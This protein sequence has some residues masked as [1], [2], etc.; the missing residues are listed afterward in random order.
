MPN[1]ASR[2]V[3]AGRRQIRSLVLGFAVTG[4]FFAALW[5]TRPERLVRLVWPL[6]VRT[7][8]DIR[9]GPY[10]QNRLDLMLPRWSFQRERPAV[11][12][13]HGG[14]WR[15]GD[16]Y[17]ARYNLCRRYLSQ[18]F[19]VANVDYRLG[20]IPLAA[21][22]AA[23]AWRWFSEVAQKYGADPRRIVITGVSAGAHLA[24]LTAFQSPVQPA[25][26]VNFYAPSNLQLLLS[27]HLIPDVLFGEN[28]AS[29]ARRLSPQTY[30]RPGLPPV[31][32]VHGT[33]DEIV[34]PA[35][36]VAL[37]ESIRAAGGEASVLFIQDGKHGFS[38]RQQEIA[39]AAVFAFLRQRG[40]L[41]P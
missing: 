9:Y 28:A 20:A 11:L 26:V 13:F 10:P 27:S 8:P 7:V 35:Q 6:W 36:T 39:Y 23:T 30:I 3:A 17:Q 5:R 24:L 41:R 12:V 38:P 22:D 31:F 29:L 32:S 14:G 16:R 37:T 4:L 15:S 1:S 2:R 34:P 21:E 40:I 18:G 25:A 33:G 19:L